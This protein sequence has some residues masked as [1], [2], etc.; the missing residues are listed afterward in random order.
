MSETVLDSSLADTQALKDM[1][2]ESVGLFE[3]EKVPL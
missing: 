1:D 3:G 2:S